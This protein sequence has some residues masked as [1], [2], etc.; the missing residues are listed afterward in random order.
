MD[1]LS[2]VLVALVGILHIY[3]LYLEMFMW[4]KPIGL[5]TF[6]MSPEK[7]KMTAPLA[8]NQGL[9]NGFLAAGL[10][11]SLFVT[12]PDTAHSFKVF[13]LS[14][15]AIAGVFGA[16]TVSKRIFFIQSLPAILALVI[17]VLC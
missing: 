10:L 11:Y 16:G 5:K 12:N 4:K 9:Y 13:F 8:A 17:I 7:A 2:T 14:C 1:T 15:V 3:F 6:R